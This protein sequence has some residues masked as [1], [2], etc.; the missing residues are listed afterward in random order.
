MGREVFT[1]VYKG[2]KI[3]LNLFSLSHLVHR[4]ISSSNTSNY[5]V[6]PSSSRSSASSSA[7]PT[8]NSC[9]KCVGNPGIIH[10]RM[11]DFSHCFLG[12]NAWMTSQL[13]VALICELSGS[14]MCLAYFVIY[15]CCHNQALADVRST[16]AGIK[17]LYCSASSSI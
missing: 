10:D 3:N 15:E 4:S 7:V 11:P 16:G 5:N 2:E 9:N 14:F 6:L 1:S 17:C 12:V 8:L 13:N